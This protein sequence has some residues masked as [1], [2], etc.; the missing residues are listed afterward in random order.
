MTKD[1]DRVAYRDVLDETIIKLLE[2]D[3][4]I[5][6]LYITKENFT[7]DIDEL[8]ERSSLN[9]EF[10]DLKKDLCGQLNTKLKTLKIN[11]NQNQL[12]QKFTKAQALGLFLK[13]MK[14]DSLE[15]KNINIY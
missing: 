9:I 8:L 7:I 2:L 10:E 11:T 5:D 3:M 12:K 13:H 6:D 14:N 1:V 15:N 4:S